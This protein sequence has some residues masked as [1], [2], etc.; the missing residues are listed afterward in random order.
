MGEDRDF[1]PNLHAA[2]EA[3][4]E[5]WGDPDYVVAKRA[6]RA[7]LDA[8]RGPGEFEPPPSRS[9]R[10]GVRNALRQRRRERGA[11]PLLDDWAAAF[12]RGTEVEE[13]EAP[14]H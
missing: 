13:P 5:A 12:D 14:G 4:L 10:A 9:A 8:C 2:F 6:V 1:D 3:L 11:S 7:A